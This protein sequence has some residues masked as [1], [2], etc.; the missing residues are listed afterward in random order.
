MLPAGEKENRIKRE[1][2]GKACR[3]VSR[4]F[5]SSMHLLIVL[6][7]QKAISSLFSINSCMKFKY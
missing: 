4:V 6:S 2:Q 5:Q 7:E 1:F 3:L